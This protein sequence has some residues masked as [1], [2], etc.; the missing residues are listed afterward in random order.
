[1]PFSWWWVPLGLAAVTAVTFLLW[2]PLRTSARK[3]RLAQARK[4][5]HQQR[6]RLEAKFIRLAAAHVKADAPRWADCEFDDSV[7][8][9][10]SRSTG[11]LSAFVAVTV[12]LES[13]SRSPVTAT[14]LMSN[15]RAGTAIF[16]FDKDHWETDGRVILNLSPNE[17]IRFY[18]S[19]LEVVDQE[20]VEPR[21][22]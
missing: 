12:A 6:E 19:D 16:R 15:L 8:Y 10:R 3:S 18:R 21:D 11:E 1:M 7:A 9:V 22:A 13:A 5:F 4:G 17:A 14:D 2:R 20:L